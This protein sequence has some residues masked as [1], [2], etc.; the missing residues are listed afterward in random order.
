MA[1]RFLPLL[2]LCVAQDPNDAFEDIPPAFNLL[3][4]KT[5]LH[6]GSN[7]RELPDYLFPAPNPAVNVTAGICLSNMT[8]KEAEQ[9]IYEVAAQ[10]GEDG[11]CTYGFAGLWASG[12]AVTRRLGTA[13]P[14]ST[15]SLWFDLTIIFQLTDSICIL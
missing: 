6:K 8:R 11:F 2:V 9:P 4:T 7:Q 3:Q 1:F 14:Y 13:I 15:Q 12:C 5:H 10:R